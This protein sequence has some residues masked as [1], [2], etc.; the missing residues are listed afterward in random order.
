MLK[1]MITSLIDSGK[2]QKDIEAGTGVPQPVISRLYSGKQKTVGYED[3]K[4]IEA[5]FKKASR[6]RSEKI[7]A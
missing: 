2:S 6:K 5:F 4:A 1:Q 7:A 3:G